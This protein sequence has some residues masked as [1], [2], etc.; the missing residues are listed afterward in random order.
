MS[1]TKFSVVII[2]GG[3]AGL[4]AALVLGR[5][6]IDTLV[7]NT[8]RPRNGV[9]Q[10]SNGFLTQDGK[11]PTEILAQATKEL[12]KYNTVVYK[13]EE[14]LSLEQSDNGFSVRAKET[15]YLSNRVIIASGY[16]DNI[17]ALGINGLTDVY[18]KSVYPCPFCDGFELA[19]KKLA[20]FGNALVAPFISMVAWNWSKDVIAFTNGES[21]EDEVILNEFKQQG[22]PIVED[23]IKTLHHT[24]GL[25]TGVELKNGEIISREAGFVRDTKAFEST[26][27]ANNFNLSWEPGHFG[28]HVYKVDDNKETEVKGL[29]IIGDAQSAWTGV[30]A[31]VAN[32]SDVAQ[33]IT[34]QIL[35]ENWSNTLKN[36]THENILE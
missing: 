12:L 17:P 33:A 24:Q 7:L 23:K 32:G 29:Y 16:K 18:G 19:N 26:P 10:H 21:V 14:A 22:I 35:Q 5:S 34:I 1:H 9:T 27:F 2:G 13:T 25:L 15:I 11:H 4:S 36:K 31:A 6:K 20:V 3:P 8:E 30:A 28:A